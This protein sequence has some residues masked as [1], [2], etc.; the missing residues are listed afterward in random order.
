MSFPLWSLTNWSHTESKVT[1]GGK[2]FTGRVSDLVC[3]QCRADLPRPSPQ[4][5]ERSSGSPPRPWGLRSV[6]SCVESTSELKKKEH[7]TQNAVLFLFFSPRAGRSFTYSSKTQKEA[8]TGCLWICSPRL[9]AKFTSGV[10]VLMVTSGSFAVGSRETEVSVVDFFVESRKTR[11]TE[12]GCM[13]YGTIMYYQAGN[14]CWS[15]I[16]KKQKK[17][18]YIITKKK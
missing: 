14:E 16:E 3:V 10:S 8:L 7:I 12:S 15:I 5:A 4:W 13:H 9:F 11:L 17:Q 2:I 6:W 1:R 18:T